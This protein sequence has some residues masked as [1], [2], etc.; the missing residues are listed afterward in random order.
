MHIRAKDIYGSLKLKS[1]A[2]MIDNSFD[3]ESYGLLVKSSLQRNM[4]VDSILL[5]EQ[6][7]GLG[8]CILERHIDSLRSRCTNIGIKHP[9]IPQ[10]PLE[11]RKLLKESRK[12][13]IDWPLKRRRKALMN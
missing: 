3:G 1:R 8:H 12:A 6:S 10:N 9:G 7:V 5:L 13:S 2:E 11:W 4:I